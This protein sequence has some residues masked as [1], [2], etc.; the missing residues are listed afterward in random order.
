MLLDA[1]QF[2]K[3]YVTVHVTGFSVERFLNIAAF[4]GIYLWDVKRTETGVV[5]NVSIPGYK[6][7]K[8][9]ARKTNCKLRIH[10]K[11][12]Y[13]FIVYRY[14]KR[15]ILWGGVLFFVLGLYALSSFI[16]R[17]DIAGRERISPEAVLA[18]CEQYGLKVGAFK[19][20][21]NHKQLQKDLPLNFPEIAWAD[22][23]TKGTRTTVT[24][25][26]TIPKQPLLDKETPCHIVAAKDGLITGI[27]TGAGK[28][29]V[30]RHDIV[31]QGE[32]LVSGALELNSDLQGISTVYVHAYAEIW[33]KRF[34]PII[35]TVPY[36]YMEKIYT[37]KNKTQYEIQL[38]FANGK[39][40]TLP[41]GSQKLESY[42]K[43]T[44][45]RQP[46]V[47]GDYPLPFVFITSHYYEFVYEPRTRD[48]ETA[49][50]LAE[51][52][53]TGRVLREFDFST[54]I[55]DK[56]VKYFDSPEGLRVEA[57]IVTNERIDAAVPINEAVRPQGIPFD[58]TADAFEPLE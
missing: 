32:L 8:N 57:L 53:L 45:R 58:E 24:I 22:V 50:Y 18:F 51:R 46:G 43:I 5:M 33:A 27:V 55:I 36:E 26:E 1:R 48:A 13:P 49:L 47:S 15:K 17:I 10:K 29:L 54:D 23:H 40:I 19:Y 20:S 35:F 14:R 3:G 41:S 9:S 37:G 56:S 31:K 39:R 2:V 42:D 28:P 34:N 25:S 4:H 11:N 38:L 30:R 6:M 21:I 7:L 44:H 52:M 16:W 12:G